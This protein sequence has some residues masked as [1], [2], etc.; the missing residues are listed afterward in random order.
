MWAP[1][2]SSENWQ[3]SN[4][5]SFESC[6]SVAHSDMKN[7][8]LLVSDVFSMLLCPVLASTA[9]SYRPHCTRQIVKRVQHRATK[10]TEELKHLSYEERLIR[11]RTVQPRREK[12]RR[13]L[14]VYKYLKEGCKEDRARLFSVVPSAR[15][16]GSGHKLED[17]RVPLNISNPSVLCGWQSTGAGCP[18]KS[19]SLLLEDLQKPPRGP[20]QPVLG[21]PAGAGGW[22][23]WSPEV[24]STLSCSVVHLLNS[25]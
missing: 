20:G 11:A 1:V 9:A 7:L 19:W 2:R 18:E 22:A 24:P 5:Q 16:R 21:G 23:R 4:A 6:C 17:R 3:C 10:M 8:S 13:N 12:A 15:T 14:S 25:L